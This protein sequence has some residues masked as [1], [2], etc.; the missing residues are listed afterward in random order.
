VEEMRREVS[1]K[2]K[3]PAV[4]VHGGSDNLIL[5]T[6]GSVKPWKLMI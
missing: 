5:S 3:D 6:G 2:V 1:A 4:V